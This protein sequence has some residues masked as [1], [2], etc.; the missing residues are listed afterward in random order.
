M[1]QIPLENLIVDFDM[2]PRNEVSDQ[3]IAGL[4]DALQCGRELPPITVCKETNRIVDGVH[5]F[6]AYRKLNYET[7]TAISKTY[8]N[9]AELFEDAV[10]LNSDHGRALDS[11]DLK[12]IIIVLGKYE[13][14]NDQIA[15]IVHIP[16]AKLEKIT[17][18]FAIDK[19]SGE[20]VPLKRGVLQFAGAPI[21]KQQQQVVKSSSGME[22][23]YHARQLIMLLEADMWKR[24]PQFI[25]A[26]DSLTVLWNDIQAREIA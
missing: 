23:T 14:S 19:E 8:K 21:T 20:P 12:K 22:G 24:T 13:Y 16:P 4:I 11:Y 5:R 9:D 6:R 17:R 7:I 10:R 25:E 3:T 2:Y 26:M 1:E 15:N 18:S